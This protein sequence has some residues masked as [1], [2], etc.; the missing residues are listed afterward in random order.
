[1]SLSVAVGTFLDTLGCYRAGAAFP[2]HDQ[3]GSR[4]R[5]PSPCPAD[6]RCR[7]GRGAAASYDPARP[8]SPPTSTERRATGKGRPRLNAFSRQALIRQLEYDRCSPKTQHSPSTASPLTGMNGGEN[9]TD[10]LGY[11]AFA[12]DGRIGRLEHDR[13]TPAAGGVRRS[14]RRAARSPFRR[15][16][17]TVSVGS[18]GAFGGNGGDGEAADAALSAAGG[19][20]RG[21][22]L[23]GCSHRSGCSAATAAPAETRRD[24]S[25]PAAALAVPAEYR[26]AASAESVAPAANDGRRLQPQPGIV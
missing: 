17:P 3:A 6:Q 26:R 10:Y 11:T 15:G 23:G 19:A 5:A 16:P 18:G 12:H 8:L 7:R 13:S 24:A 25:A 14:R 4:C 20:A 22:V 2:R 9:A 1:M 21:Q